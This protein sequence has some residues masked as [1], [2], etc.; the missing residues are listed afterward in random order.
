MS[1]SEVKYSRK[2]DDEGAE[3]FKDNVE[4]V[5]SGTDSSQQGYQE[6]SR[7]N[8]FSR[9]EAAKMKEATVDSGEEFNR[10]Y[11]LTPLDTSTRVKRPNISDSN[12]T[13]GSTTPSYSIDP[14]EVASPTDREMEENETFFRPD[15]PSR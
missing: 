11:D 15:Q 2:L 7:S 1:S 13:R 6:G 3:Y 12:D 10:Q 9:L 4:D 5:T 8:T 14:W